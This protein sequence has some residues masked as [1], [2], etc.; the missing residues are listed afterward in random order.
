MSSS[1]NINDE[2]GAGLERGDTLP[3]S[4]YS[5]PAIFE[6]EKKRIFGRL[7]QYVGHAGQVEKPGD[8][9]TTQLG[10]V[11]V[12]VARDNGGQLR[13]FANVCRHRGSEV[14]LEASGCRQTLQCHYHGW[15][16]NLDGTLRAAPRASE[17]SSFDK[18]ALSLIS[19]PIENW[20]PLIFVNPD[21]AA[22]PLCELLGPLPGIFT[23]AGVD[24]RG[25]RLF[26]RDVY[27]L[28]ANWKIVI[29]NFNECYHCPVAHPRF[30]EMIDTEAY[31]VD[32][33]HEFFSIY[34]GPYLRAR[35]QGVTY[36]TLWPTA[37]FALSDNPPS[38]QVLCVR[39]LDAEH[40]YE[41]IDYYF[42]EGATEDYIKGYIELSD[43]VQ[44]EDVILCESV[45]RGLKSAAVKK[46]QL[47]LSRERGI[48]HFQQLVYRAVA[49]SES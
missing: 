45:Q 14:V 3:A 36:A 19:F 27:K 34:Y 35:S 37:M 40:T 15:T 4:W 47:M 41:T 26:R 39:P 42:A 18:G 30:S 8:F 23:R 31:R 2:I 24:V 43:L 9:F 29:E 20:G 49:G 22:A 11:P 10:D 32:T 17:Q 1:L 46:G 25:L 7:W 16:Y 44:R 12:I 5:D 33:D 38:M 13:A 28:A 6:A 21:P 48:Q